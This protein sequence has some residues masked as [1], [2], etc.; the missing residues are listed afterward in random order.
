MTNR[1]TM[2]QRQS[3]SVSFTQCHYCKETRWIESGVCHSVRA[4]CCSVMTHPMNCIHL[5][6]L[7][8]CDMFVCIL[9]VSHP[10][11]CLLPYADL[12]A[13]SWLWDGQFQR[14][15]AQLCGSVRRRQVILTFLFKHFPS[16]CP[17]SKM[18][19]VSFAFSL[20]NTIWVKSRKIW[21]LLKLRVFFVR[22]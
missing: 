11:S 6:S 16:F 4:C 21:S 19:S 7:K 5:L 20:L 17:I 10:Y 1:R 13:F 9:S 3:G 2:I 22:F 18:S 12:P 8:D 14:V 15:Q